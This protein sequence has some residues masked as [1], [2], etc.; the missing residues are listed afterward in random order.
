MPRCSWILPATRRSIVA[1]SA[2]WSS[3]D[4]VIVRALPAPGHGGRDAGHPCPLL[5]PPDPAL[6]EL[7]AVLRQPLARDQ[8]VV[9][10]SLYELDGALARVIEAGATPQLDGQALSGVSQLGQP[11][12]VLGPVRHV[13]VLQRDGRLAARLST[14]EARHLS[15]HA[16]RVQ[17]DEGQRA[18]V[19]ELA[20]PDALPEATALPARTTAI[21]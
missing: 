10:V 5:S 20:D 19:V 12:Q 17:V 1:L 11:T 15:A 18:V 14:E 7:A 8:T 21:W 4:E 9:E 2:A 6:V 13:A 3:V 16:L